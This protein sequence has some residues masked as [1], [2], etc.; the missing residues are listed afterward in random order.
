MFSRT[1]PLVVDAVEDGLGPPTKTS[2][3]LHRP[4]LRGSPR[5]RGAPDL[6]PWARRF[7]DAGLLAGART[8]TGIQDLRLAWTP[9][10]RRWRL[11]LQTLAGALVGTAPGSSIAVPLEP[12]DIDGL[13]RILRA[14]RNA[15]ATPA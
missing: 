1:W 11:R 13:L 9:E 5:L 2:L 8:M 15:L 10:D 12:D 7:A 6:D 14:F 4:R 3:R